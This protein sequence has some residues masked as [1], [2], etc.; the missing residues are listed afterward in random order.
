LVPPLITL[1][2]ITALLPIDY[3][4]F[5]SITTDSGGS[6]TGIIKGKV[7]T[8]DPNLPSGASAFDLKVG[9]YT[10]TGT[11]AT[12]SNILSVNLNIP[13]PSPS[14]T[15][16]PKSSV[17]NSSPT[18][19]PSKNSI[20]ISNSPGSINS[21]DSFTVSIS[22]MDDKSSD[23][24]LKGA[25]LKTG[26]SNYFGKT[27]VSSNWV[28]NS[29]SAQ[30]QFKVTTNTDG[31]WNSTLEVMPDTDDSGFLGSGSYTFKVGRY[32]KDGDDLTWSNE[33]TIQIIQTSISSPK[34]SQSTPTSTKLPSSS[35]L[36]SSESSSESSYFDDSSV[37]GATINIPF[38]PSEKV[39]ESSINTISHL[40]NLLKI[41][42]GFIVLF[43]GLFI[44]AENKYPQY[45]TKFKKILKISSK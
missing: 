2:G 44:F 13:S 28:K 26:S 39:A 17:A 21:S 43:T 38:G 10:E 33:T 25:F 16:S 32:N 11:S 37:A 1:V 15:V 36:S 3:S 9:R 22:L 29:S 19:T 40:P 14:S 12:W 34:S 4:K 31:N 23:F 6:F 27:K 24:F 41:I 18:P 30:N 7:E 42:A 5:L 8:S 35:S 20:V 45:F